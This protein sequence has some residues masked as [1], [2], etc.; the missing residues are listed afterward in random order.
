MPHCMPDC[1]I[2][3]SETWFTRWSMTG[4]NQWSPQA[5]IIDFP[6]SKFIF[7][8]FVH[9][10]KSCDLRVRWVF[11]SLGVQPLWT[12][13]GETNLWGSLALLSEEKLQRSLGWGFEDYRWRGRSASLVE[14]ISANCFENDRVERKFFNFQLDQ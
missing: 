1:P 11:G 8:W 7:R 6:F 14:G 9:Q 13:D 5:M 2:C 4:W 3:S 12:G 10:G